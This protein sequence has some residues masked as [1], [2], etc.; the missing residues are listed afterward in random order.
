M[1]QRLTIWWNVF[2]HYLRFL[3]GDTAYANYLA[4][5]D[6]AHSSTDVPLSRADFFK[7]ETDRRWC[8]V[9]RCC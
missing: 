5:W 9:R 1:A 3:N 8:S 6:Q 4:H 7:Q 2:R